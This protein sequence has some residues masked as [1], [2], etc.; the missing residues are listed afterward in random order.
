MLIGMTVVFI[1]LSL[2]IFF[3]NFFRRILASATINE[4]EQA[5]AQVAASKPKAQG[6]GEEAT[7]LT[8]VVTAAVEAHLSKKKT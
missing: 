6:G 5:K 1:Y 4:Q 7:R 3:I 8:A 2:M